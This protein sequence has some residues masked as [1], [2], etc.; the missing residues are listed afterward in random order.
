MEKI[1]LET[2]IQKNLKYYSIMDI[3]KREEI[4]QSDKEE[5]FFFEIFEGNFEFLIEIVQKEKKR[6]KW[7]NELNLKIKDSKLKDLIE[8]FENSLRDCL[9]NKYIAKFS[10][11]NL[12]IFLRK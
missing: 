3:K 4:Q 1:S 7:V 5:N 2:I 11:M 12:L 6:K 10:G 9:S 8:K